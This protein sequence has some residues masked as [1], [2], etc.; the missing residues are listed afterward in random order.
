M[1]L[2]VGK[3]VLCLTVKIDFYR[4]FIVCLSCIRLLSCRSLTFSQLSARKSSKFLF[5]FLQTLNVS[6]RLLLHIKAAALVLDI[7]MLHVWIPHWWILYRALLI[8]ANVTSQRSCTLH[9]R[10]FNSCQRWSITCHTY[11]CTVHALDEFPSLCQ[12]ETQL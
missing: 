3:P 12:G 1:Y 5:S 2:N 11:I 10:T 8:W 7:Q 4:N 6:L 9:S